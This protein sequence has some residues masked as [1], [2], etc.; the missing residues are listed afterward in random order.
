[1]KIE[2]DDK[3]DLLYLRFDESFQEVINL[4]VN[5]NIVLDLGK[6][7]KI[8]GIEI[9]DATEVVNLSTILPIE[10]Q[11]YGSQATLAS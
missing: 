10:Y 2:Y 11:I 6:D 9:L 3:H 8:I 5:D 7:N 4:K 1:M